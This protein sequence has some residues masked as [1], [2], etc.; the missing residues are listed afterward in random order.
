MSRIYNATEIYIILIILRF[1]ILAPFF[2]NVSSIFN[3]F[4]HSPPD[5]DSLFLLC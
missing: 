4:S 5:P 2:P 3:I 1:L